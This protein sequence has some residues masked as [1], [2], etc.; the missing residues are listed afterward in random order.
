MN[1]EIAEAG[2]LHVVRCPG[3]V[4]LRSSRVL[5]AGH[6]FLYTGRDKKA[7]RKHSHQPCTLNKI[8]SEL[9][10]LDHCRLEFTAGSESLRRGGVPAPPSGP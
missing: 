2:V 6:C 7:F 8:S 5:M 4:G 1:V 10:A 3:F 9:P